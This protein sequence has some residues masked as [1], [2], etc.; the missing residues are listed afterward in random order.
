MAGESAVI[1]NENELR[2]AQDNLRKLEQVLIAARQSHTSED[3]PRMA[4]PFL[5]EMQERRR[6]ILTYMA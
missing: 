5:L 6:E 3:Y 4:E 1:R 2:A